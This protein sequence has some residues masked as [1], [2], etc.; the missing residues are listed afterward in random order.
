MPVFHTEELD[1]H[2]EI[3]AKGYRWFLFTVLAQ[4][5]STGNINWSFSQQGITRA[6]AILR[7]SA[8][9]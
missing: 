2:Y 8:V 5:S 1:F 6:V 9:E 4:V 3:Q 7:A